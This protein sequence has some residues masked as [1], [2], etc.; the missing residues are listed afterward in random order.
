MSKLLPPVS[1]FHPPAA[2]PG[3][4]TFTYVSDGDANGVLYFAG[5]NWSSGGVWTNPHTAGYITAVRSSSGNGD[6]PEILVD[7]TTND[8]FTNNVANSWIA[9]DLGPGRSFS[10]TKYTLRH[11]V[12][13]DEKIRNWKLQGT[14]SAASDSVADLAAATWTDIETRINDTTI[15]APNAY[16]TF[17]LSSA[18]AY[19]RYFRILQ[20]GVTNNGLD[21]L[22]VVE[23]EFYGTLAP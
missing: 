16:G 1:N 4:G 2:P 13:T 20:N 7:R 14:N 11:Y 21:Y 15:N 23:I 18:S 22:A 17:T 9:I 3:A 8:T 19:F 10:V 5:K 12:S 6:G